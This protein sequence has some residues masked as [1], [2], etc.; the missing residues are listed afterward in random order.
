MKWRKFRHCQYPNAKQLLWNRTL[1]TVQ[2]SRGIRVALRG[3]LNGNRKAAGFGFSSPLCSH[4]CHQMLQGGRQ[5]WTNKTFSSSS[6]FD[7]FNIK[8]PPQGQSWE[9]ELQPKRQT[10][11]TQ[12]RSLCAD[13]L[14]PYNNLTHGLSS[15]E[16][17]E[18]Q[19][20]EE[21]RGYERWNKQRL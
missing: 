13:L 12:A 8:G 9:M 15:R 19:M 21:K 18:R 5:V 10:T 11:W 7:V 3:L 20:E 17:W 1:V 6:H 2:W 4:R 16:Q 14:T